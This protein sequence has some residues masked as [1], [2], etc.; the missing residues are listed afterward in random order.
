MH[1]P[2]FDNLNFFQAGYLEAFIKEDPLDLSLWRW[3]AVFIEVR[4]S[5]VQLD[6]PAWVN[7][8]GTIG[9][10]EKTSLTGVR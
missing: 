3:I 8:S 6:I 1:L 4:I 10:R 2:L 9:A 5:S 7:Q